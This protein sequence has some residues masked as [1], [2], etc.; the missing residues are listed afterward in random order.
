MEEAML[1][2]LSVSSFLT[3]H[4]ISFNRTLFF[5]DIH[6]IHNNNGAIN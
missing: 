3:I 6:A 1:E 2:P 4:V 5:N